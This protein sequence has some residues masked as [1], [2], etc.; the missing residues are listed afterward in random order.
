M[1]AVKNNISEKDLL[2]YYVTELKENILPFWERNCI[3]KENGGYFNCFSNDGKQLLSHDKFTWSQGRFVWI[4][5]KLSMLKSDIFSK[6]QR[7]KYLSFAANGIDFL[8]K[9][10]LMGP[11]DWRCV[12]LNDEHGNHKYPS[13]QTVL[14]G[15]I[16]ADCF[17]IIA[18]AKYALAANDQTCYEFAIKLYRSCLTQLEEKNFFTLPYPL[19]A[20]YK[21]HGIPMI[22]DD[23]TKEL[24]RTAKVLC[25]QDTEWLKAMLE[26]FSSE[27]LNCFVDENNCLR[28]VVSA[29]NSFLT[30]V[31]GEHMNPG[32]TLEDMWFTID[33]ADILGKPE[34]VE[35]AGRLALNALNLGWDKEYG[36]IL[37]FCGLTGGKPEGSRQ[38][39]EQ[40]TMLRQV[41]DG[42][43]DKLWWVHTEALYITLL[44]YYRLQRDEFLEWH[45]RILSY[46]QKHFP[47]LDREVGEWIQILDRKGAPQQKVVALPVKDPYHIIR[48]FAL[49]IEL[50]TAQ[51]SQ[52]E[53][54]N[55]K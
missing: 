26:K 4:W 27:V 49:I 2:N 41:D 19:S 47:N 44:L 25:P 18:F 54:E 6:E 40:E 38:G 50:L 24:F 21:A 46:V 12:F 53:I 28:E 1:D 15:S 20:Q 32:H 14:N 39:V 11:D 22:F 55:G 3:D 30:N 51:I 33:A 9:Y 37:H 42:W 7:E 17:V 23:V 48:N 34:W 36:G 16:Y 43:G 5:S 45:L 8:R 35:I 31:L 52:K 13:G 29:D 10:A